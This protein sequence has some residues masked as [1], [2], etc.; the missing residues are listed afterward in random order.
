MSEVT[1]RSSRSGAASATREVTRKHT[2]S[3]GSSSPTTPGPRPI[4]TSTPAPLSSSVTTRAGTCAAGYSTYSWSSPAPWGISRGIPVQLTIFSMRI[5]LSF[6]V[7]LL[8]VA[9]SGA[10]SAVGGEE[11]NGQRRES[12]DVRH[13]PDAVLAAAGGQASGLHGA[14]HPQAVLGLLP[15]DDPV[16]ARRR[17]GTALGERGL[18]QVDLEEGHSAHAQVPDVGPHAHGGDAAGAQRHLNAQ[19]QVAG[20]LPGAHVGDRRVRGLRHGLH[21][22]LPGALDGPVQ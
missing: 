9:C 3:F 14:Q 4:H 7:V 21:G 20:P 16:H 11:F 12:V 17:L 8:V 6:Q 13:G 22:A 19:A 2:H 5:R 15:G 10:M 18:L 1:S